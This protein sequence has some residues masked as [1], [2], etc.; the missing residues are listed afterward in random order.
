MKIEER[1]AFAQMDKNTVDSKD[2][3]RGRQRN[4]G[5]WF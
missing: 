4:E 1:G 2:Q 5:V 3:M